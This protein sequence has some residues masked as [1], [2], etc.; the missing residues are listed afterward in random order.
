MSLSKLLVK[1]DITSLTCV[2]RDKSEL[3]KVTK[4]EDIAKIE[5]AAE[6]DKS[7]KER[8][9]HNQNTQEVLECTN[10]TPIRFVT[11]SVA[12]SHTRLHE[13]GS[14]R[15][16]HCPRVFD[17]VM[18]RCNHERTKHTHLEKL[19][20]CG[21]CS[22][23]FQYYHQ[24]QKHLLAVHNV[25]CLAK[26][27]A[28]ERVYANQ[29]QLR[30]HI[31]KDHL[32]ERK[33][34][35]IPLDDTEQT[36]NEEEEANNVVASENIKEDPE[37]NLD[38]EIKFELL[39][40]VEEA[41]PYEGVETEDESEIVEKKVESE[42]KREMEKKTE[43]EKQ[44]EI[45][46]ETEIGEKSGI[47]ENAETEDK[48][49]TEDE[50]GPG[51]LIIVEQPDTEERAETI[52]KPQKFPT[53]TYPISTQ[54][55]QLRFGVRE[56]LEN[57]NA[58]AIRCR[59]NIGYACCFCKSQFPVPGDLK[60]HNREKHYTNIATFMQKK[61]M[62]KFFIKMDITMLECNLCKQNFDNMK[63]L[64][65]HLRDTHNKDICYELQKRILPFKFDKEDLYCC[66]CTKIFQNFKVLQ[67]H[68][69]IHY[70][71]YKCDVCNTGFVTRN[72]LLNHKASHETGEF[73]CD[74]CPRVYNTLLKKR[75]HEK[76]VHGAGKLRSKCGYCGIRMNNALTRELHYVEVHGIPRTRAAVY[77]C[78]TCNRSFNDNYLL[79]AHTQR[80]HQRVKPHKCDFCERSFFTTRE[81]AK[82]SLKH[83]SIEEYSCDECSK[84]FTRKTALLE[85]KREHRKDRR[86]KCTFCDKDFLRKWSLKLHMR[87]RHGVNMATVPDTTG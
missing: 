22:E 14:F 71:N 73:K 55:Q 33:F 63:Q 49:D 12:V 11:R 53:Q 29:R 56:I 17:T 79:I 3:T 7:Q 72:A 52:W 64:I 30:V 21:L 43:T 4:K 83:T 15:C 9:K 42:K 24:K 80:F 20:R 23:T 69:Y 51:D 10:A 5:R 50:D 6:R 65:S 46:K 62:S 68:M 75:S 66:D 47:G 81:L 8:L 87:N 44:V 39:E 32:M 16:R 36:N 58:T 67:E 70:S 82:H 35:C 41:L 78:Q 34:K 59:G 25:D 27:H 40:I 38:Y 26:C 2:P 77:T 13:T 76:F 31:R 45:A 57:S 74:H 37:N 61:D 19:N 86:F 28:C 60:R 1:L 18:K 85:H 84:T 54:L 48:L